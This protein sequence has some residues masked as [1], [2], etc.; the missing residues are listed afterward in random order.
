MATK[1]VAISKV[2]YSDRLLNYCIG[3]V[4]GACL[5]GIGALLASGAYHSATTPD[6]VL[7][8]ATVVKV[9]E[10][11]FRI[12]EGTSIAYY[13]Y[14]DQVDGPIHFSS[15]DKTRNLIPGDIVDLMVERN[16]RGDSFS[17][18]AIRRNK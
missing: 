1:E 16:P 11:I 10:R 6:I 3:T 8:G 7:Q 5:L 13:L 14:T 12:K 4:T 15:G 2:A 17:G 18:I 9:E